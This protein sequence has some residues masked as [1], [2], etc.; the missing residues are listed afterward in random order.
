MFNHGGGP[1]SLAAALALFGTLVA[2]SMTDELPPRPKYPPPPGRG[3]EPTRITGTHRYKIAGHKGFIEDR[4]AG[5]LGWS[6]VFDDDWN[7]IGTYTDQGKTY[8]HRGRERPVF[9]GDF[10]PDSS[11][12]A[13]YE[14]QSLGVEVKRSPIGPVLTLEDVAEEERESGASSG[15]SDE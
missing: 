5:D 7:L 10:E 13:L 1:A 15:D 4:A 9:L 8:R 3:T 14:I 11:L 6:L 2:C 12:R